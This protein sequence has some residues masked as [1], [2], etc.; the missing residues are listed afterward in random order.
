ME[1]AVPSYVCALRDCAGVLV[2][3]GVREC[4]GAGGGVCG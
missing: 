1:E 3:A 2:A 4:S